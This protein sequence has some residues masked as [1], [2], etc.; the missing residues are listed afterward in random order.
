MSD[1]VAAARDSI[2]TAKTRVTT[3]QTRGRGRANASVRGGRGRSV[4]SKRGRGN[5]RKANRPDNSTNSTSRGKAKGG[6]GG[7]RG[8]AEGTRG[9]ETRGN[10][11]TTQT[12]EEEARRGTISEENY[13]TGP[14]TAYHLLFGDDGARSAIPDLNK[15]VPEE[16]QISQNTPQ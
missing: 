12:T 13:N 6:R 2:P 14:G 15:N 1:F 16:V 9:E 4:A 10:I 3:A 7:T 5:K 11:E 8:C